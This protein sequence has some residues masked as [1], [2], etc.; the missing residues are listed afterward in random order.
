VQDVKRWLLVNRLMLWGAMKFNAR[1]F[2]LMSGISAAC[3]VWFHCGAALAGA[4]LTR[5]KVPGAPGGYIIAINDS[6]TMAG[7]YSDTAGSHLFEMTNGSV[8]VLPQIKVPGGVAQVTPL[9][10]N[11]AGQMLGLYCSGTC[12]GVIYYGSK[13]NFQFALGRQFDNDS[14]YT[15]QGLGLDAAIYNADESGFPFGLVP[16][17]M[18]VSVRGSVTIPAQSNGTAAFAAINDSN[19]I[20]GD[21]TTASGNSVPFILA[22]GQYRFLNVP[23]A[24][25]TQTLLINDQDMVVGVLTNAA[26]T[27]LMWAY[28]GGRYRVYFPNSTHKFILPVAVSNNGAVAVLTDGPGH[29]LQYGYIILPDESVTAIGVFPQNATPIISLNA[30]HQFIVTTTSGKVYRSFLGTY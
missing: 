3:A 12:Y 21:F 8:V 26:G 2:T 18:V 6:E 16:T 7:T 23:G 1:R 11:K 14:G 15:L 10:L 17:G 4:Q 22:G 13:D 30:R 28:R 19:V 25:S 24:A 20:A 27:Q 29:G 9:A 5:I